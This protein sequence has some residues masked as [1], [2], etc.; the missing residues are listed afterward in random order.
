MKVYVNNKTAVSGTDTR[1]IL[2]RA[3]FTLLE[4]IVALVV[5]SVL[6]NEEKK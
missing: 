3:G 5:I 2:S 6:I 4:L 1:N